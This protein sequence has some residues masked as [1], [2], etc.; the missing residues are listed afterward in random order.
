MSQ[1]DHI[2]YL[3]VS[4]E[5][6][7]IKKLPPILDSGAYTEYVGYSIENKVTNT[8]QVNSQLTYPKQV[9]IDDISTIDVSGCPVFLTCRNTNQRTNRRLTPFSGY[10]RPLRPLTQKQQGISIQ[11]SNLCLCTFK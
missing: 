5:L 11:H 1:S 8:K 4:T 6:Q 10:C 3:K 9:I 2:Q 7:S